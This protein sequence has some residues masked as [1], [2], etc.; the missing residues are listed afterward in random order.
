MTSPDK[1]TITHEGFDN[2]LA[3]QDKILLDSIAG[4]D[5]D[6]VD[7]DGQFDTLGAKIKNTCSFKFN[8]TSLSCPELEQNPTFIK[9][10]NRLI[11]FHITNEKYRVNGPTEK[12][13]EEQMRTGVPFKYLVKLHRCLKKMLREVIISDDKANQEYYLKRTYA[14]FFKT[15]RATGM[16]SSTQIE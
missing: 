3:E 1:G 16:L 9:L 8:V 5:D 14:W 15:Q 7:E 10:K 4:V 11:K 2:K 6:L 13:K 12:Q